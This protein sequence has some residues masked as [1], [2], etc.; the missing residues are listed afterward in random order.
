MC[1]KTTRQL[2]IDAG[3]QDW[4]CGVL[5]AAVEIREAKDVILCSGCPASQC[6]LSTMQT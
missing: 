4:E 3:Q 5:L 2:S 6:L 1:Q